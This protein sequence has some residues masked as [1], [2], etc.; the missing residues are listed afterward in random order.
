MHEAYAELLGLLRRGAL[1]VQLQP[2]YGLNEAAQAHRD[3]A[4]RRTVGKVVLRM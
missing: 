1:R 4:A 2:A 3:L